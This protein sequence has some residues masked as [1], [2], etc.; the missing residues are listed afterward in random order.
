MLKQ[1]LGN[2]GYQNRL[3]ENAATF[4]T[5]FVGLV[6]ILTIVGP[7]ILTIAGGYY[8]IAV[9]QLYAVFRSSTIK[10][11]KVFVFNA[12]LASFLVSFAVSWY[13]VSN[14]SQGML[15]ALTTPGFNY[16]I[17]YLGR[18]ERL[19][20]FFGVIKGMARSLRIIIAASVF[21][22][23]LAYAFTEL[24]IGAQTDSVSLQSTIT[25]LLAG[26]TIGSVYARFERQTAISI[27]QS[28]K[29]AKKSIKDTND[30]ILKS[31]IWIIL[32][33]VAII[34]GVCNARSS[35]QISDGF[36]SS[37]V[38][39][40]SGFIGASGIILIIGYI[41]IILLVLLRQYLAGLSHVVKSERGINKQITDNSKYREDWSSFPGEVAHALRKDSEN[42]EERRN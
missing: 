35:L 40:I 33:V 3:S 37:I 27:R 10:S 26:I 8:D 15:I 25:V 21:F 13:S 32:P 17:L 39:V 11:P 19:P 7:D 2:E 36:F 14:P 24:A 41:L 34:S 16:I 5:L 22:I 29:E 23:F 38:A 30:E 6:A 12:V 20:R 28:Q 9:R 4:L 18:L 31:K 42:D 1:Y